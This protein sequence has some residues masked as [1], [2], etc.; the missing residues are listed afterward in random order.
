MVGK[1]TGIVLPVTGLTPGDLQIASEAEVG[2]AEA[3][4]VLMTGVLHATDTVILPEIVEVQGIANLD[5][6]LNPVLALNP[7][8]ALNLAPSP[9]PGVVT[10]RRGPDPGT[11]RGY[12]AVTADHDPNPGTRNVASRALNLDRRK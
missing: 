9:D 11:E 4:Q 12:P 1:L 5:P 10:V 2:V 6:D 3:E 8:L 7:I